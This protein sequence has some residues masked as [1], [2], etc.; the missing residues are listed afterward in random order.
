MLNITTKEKDGIHLCTYNFGWEDTKMRGL[1]PEGWFASKF[2]GYSGVDSVKGNRSLK[3]PPLVHDIASQS[4]WMEN[5]SQ[6]LSTM[7]CS[8]KGTRPGRMD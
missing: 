5:G 4:L 7:G 1:T 2:D 8:E 3:A 6:E